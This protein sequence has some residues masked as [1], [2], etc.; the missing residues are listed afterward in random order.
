MRENPFAGVPGREK[1]AAK[2]AG[3]NFV[4]YTGEVQQAN[5][6]Q[7]FAW[8]ARCQGVDVHALAEPTKLEQYKKDFEEQKEK[9]K[10]EHMEK[11]IEKYG[12]RE[13]IEAPPK[14]L[15]PQQTEQYVEYSRTGNVV[16]G[17]EK[18]TAKSRFDEDVYP[19]N[20][21]SVWGSYWEDGKWGFKCCRATMKNAYCTRVAK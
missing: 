8:S 1:E 11:L 19:M 2:F 15:L 14:D 13:H 21:T 5:E 3:E 6:A 12:G 16:K 18:A 20:H 4:R 7:V 10:K 17:Q 9:S